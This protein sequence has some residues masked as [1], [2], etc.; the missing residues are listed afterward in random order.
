MPNPLLQA[1]ILSFASPQSNCLHCSRPL[2]G[3]S[4]ARCNCGGAGWDRRRPGTGVA[5]AFLGHALPF[6]GHA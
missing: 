3:A 1:G 5:E 4:G 6:R 2:A